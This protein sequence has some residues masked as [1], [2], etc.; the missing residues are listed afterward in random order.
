MQHFEVITSEG[1]IKLSISN[2]FYLYQAVEDVDL[3]MKRGS[4]ETRTCDGSVVVENIIRHSSLGMKS[5]I[6]AK[7]SFNNGHDQAH[8]EFTRLKAPI[9][10]CNHE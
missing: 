7:L 5:M 10:F 6:S 8:L 2:N 1:H 9:P 4:L 3:Q